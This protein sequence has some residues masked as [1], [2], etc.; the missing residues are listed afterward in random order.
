MF[1][2]SDP[3][4]YSILFA[5][6]EALAIVTFTH[7]FVK[8]FKKAM[9]RKIKETYQPSDDLKLV[10][11]RIVS[12]LLYFVGIG[13][14]LF[15]LHAD[16]WFYYIHSFNALLGK[17]VQ[18][19][20][21]WIAAYFVVKYFSNV[22]E[23]IDAHIS[24]A[25]LSYHTHALIKQFFKYTVYT[26][27]I[28]ITLYIF[29]LESGLAAL[30][31]G[32]GVG[33]IVIGFAAKDVFSNMLSGIFLIL[34]KPFK[35]GDAIEV[36][37]TNISGTVQGISIRS[38]DIKSFEGKYITI[39]NLLLANHAIINYSRSTQ[40]RI[41]IPVGIA[42]ES[43]ISKAISVIKETVSKVKGVL[44]DRGINVIVSDLGPSS[45]DLIVRFWADLNKRS[46]VDIKSEITA[47]IKQ[48]LDKA[49][50]EIP[51][52]KQVLIQKKD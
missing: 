19:A 39:P 41:E 20:V 45:V 13:S 14:A 23:V 29:N 15:V 12:V 2:L 44:T 16:Q 28:I 26:I 7:Y 10:I 31:A 48:A 42:Y 36:I 40:R 34:D 22:F 8:F 30:L 17:G 1:S 4:L 5:I 35:V 47:N 38:T 32:A 9:E 18:A 52:P 46:L 49:G 50:I 21:T 43:D 3:A 51:Y 24:I 33:G 25:S 11:L 37:G 27:A 6:I